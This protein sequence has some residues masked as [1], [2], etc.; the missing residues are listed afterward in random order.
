[1]EDVEYSFNEF[2]GIEFNIVILFNNLSK[3]KEAEKKY[4]SD[5]IFMKFN[6]FK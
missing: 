1:M 5:D 3:G 4:K 6:A 2:R